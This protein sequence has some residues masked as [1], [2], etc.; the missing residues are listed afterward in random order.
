MTAQPSASTA[1]DNFY[2]YYAEESLSAET[3]ARFN[4]VR[5]VVMRL[6]TREGRP[7]KG[8][9]VVDIGCGAATQCLIWAREGNRVHGVDVN[10]R[11]LDLG[12]QRAAAEGLNVDLRTGTALDVPWPDNS[13][14]VVLMPE[15]LEHVADWKRCL[16]EAVRI[17]RPGG[18]FY[19]STTNRLCPS[20]EEFNLPAYAWYPTW[21]KKHY[22]KLA[23]TTRPEVAN[24]AKYPAVHWFTF[25]ELRDF[26]RQRGLQSFDRF[27]VIDTEGR[28]ALA[29]AVVGTVRSA[30]ILRFCGQILTPYSLVFA[31]KR[32]TDASSVRA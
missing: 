13:M 16:D 24:Y 28:G 10:A 30:G 20:Q 8:L 3:F 21:L 2:K 18:V 9:D 7:T 11:L 23:F 22:E 19:V 14:D 15:L 1:E 12:R 32:G 27:D 26:L 6:L 31:I 25:Y 5:S 4:S 29:K 17:M